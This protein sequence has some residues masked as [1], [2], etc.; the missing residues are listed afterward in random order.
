MRLAALLLLTFS[1]AAS[2]AAAPPPDALRAFDA[3]VAQVEARV[4]NEQRSPDMFLR[5]Q[6]LPPAARDE[7]ERRLRAGEILVESVG[8]MRRHVPG[9]M[10]HHWLG[11]A[12]IAGTTIPQTLAL[13][14][15]YDDL[16]RYYQPEVLRSRLLARHGDD[17]QIFMRLRKHKVITVVLDTY[18][19][20]HYGRLDAAHSYSMS[21]STRIDEI[22]DAGQ[23]SEHAVAPGSD[24]GFLWRLNT[25]WRFVQVPDGVVV[26][27]EAVSLTRDVPAGLG[28][29]VGP[30]VR[31][32]PRESLQF[33][34][35]ATRNALSGALATAKKEQ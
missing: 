34:L 10:I 18:Y 26:Q 21:R 2:A 31:D 20:V 9:G 17:F 8:Q 19:D 32:I 24:H 23:R 6:T 11:T 7:A 5:L 35:G 30:F 33:T 14:Q 25:Y 27:C 29:L 22:A 16:P 15:N 12:F 4:A 13:V 1:A 3:Y 28:W